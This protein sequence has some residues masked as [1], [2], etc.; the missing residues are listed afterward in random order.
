MPRRAPTAGSS[1]I[2]SL[3]SRVQ[4][5]QPEF[6]RLLGVSAETYRTW[7]SGRRTVPDAWLD[8]A[9][10]LAAINDPDRLWSLQKLAIQLGVHVRT[11]RGA[12]RSGRL[13]VTYDNRVVFRNLVPKATWA[14]GHA[15]IERYYRQSY[16]R[17]APK[18]RPPERTPAPPDSAARLLRIRHEL[19]LTQ[20]RLADQ[21]GAA[22]KAVVY[23]W[24]SGKRK[25]SPMF[26]GRIEELVE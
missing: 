21:I 4:R 20:A 12:A 17:F 2:R 9:R 7:D 1:E 10:A 24:E 25:P 15:F 23:Q 22:G 8:K 18:P 3:R 6:A 14:A 5:S 11:L 16:S 26:W 13:A 19:G